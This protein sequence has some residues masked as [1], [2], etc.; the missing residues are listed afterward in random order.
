MT[1]KGHTLKA[2]REAYWANKKPTTPDKVEILEPTDSRMTNRYGSTIN[3]EVVKPNRA[4]LRA[5][6]WRSN[7]RKSPFNQTKRAARKDATTAS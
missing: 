4:S 7:R 1:E 2:Q 6:G 3:G 5:R